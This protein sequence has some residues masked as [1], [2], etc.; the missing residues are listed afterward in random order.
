MK[1]RLHSLFDVL[2]SKTFKMTGATLIAIAACSPA[3]LLAQE[4]KL[5]VVSNDSTA[6][7]YLGTRQNPTSY[8]AGT[9]RV[10]GTLDINQGDITKSAFN[11]TIFAANG[12][13]ADPQFKFQSKR[14]RLLSDGRLEVTGKLSVLEVSRQAYTSFGEDFS[15]PTYGP[16]TTSTTSQPATFTFALPFVSSMSSQASPDGSRG[17]ALVEANVHLTNEPIL[18]TATT[19]VNGERFPELEHSIVST[20]WPLGINNED[21]SAPTSVGEDFSGPV[22]SFTNVPSVAP[23]TEPTQF[24]EDYAGA[25][26]VPPAGNQVAIELHLELDNAAGNMSPVMSHSTSSSASADNAV[27]AGE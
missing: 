1:S 19:T 17:P 21:C 27:R 26:F 2:K 20:A 18:V 11:L 3:E 13:A 12:S 15:G 16:P 14:V 5:Q 10:A 23:Q 25:S 22:C 24:G 8:G 7:M 4:A 9:L 6:D